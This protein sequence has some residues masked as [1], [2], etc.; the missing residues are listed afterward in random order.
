M[1]G[2]KLMAYPNDIRIKALEHCKNG[3]TE[4]QVSEKVGVSKQT[5]GNWK[6]LLFATGGIEKKKVERKSGKPYKYT[7]EKIGALLDKT[8]KSDSATVSKDDKAQGA[9]KI[10]KQ[11]DV[12]EIKGSKEA[13]DSKKKKKPKAQLKL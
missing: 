12:K 13:K 8:Q 6:K 2:G 7:P 5:V 4:A 11:S 1:K 10:P 9:P 3:L